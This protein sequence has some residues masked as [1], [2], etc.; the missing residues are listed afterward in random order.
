[1]QDG[2]VQVDF[3]ECTSTK[4]KIPGWRSTGSLHGMYLN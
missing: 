1:M 4:T 2:E 3:M